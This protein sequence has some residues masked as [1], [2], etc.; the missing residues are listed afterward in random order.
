MIGFIGFGRMGSALVKG[1]IAS[2]FLKPSQLIV[3]DSSVE[4]R[5]SAKVLRLQVATDASEVVRKSDIVFLCVKPQG[6]EVVLSEL[7]GL[8][9]KT[10]FVS[11][12]AGIPIGKLERWLGK[13][14]SVFRVM[15]NTPALLQA[16]MSALS[17]GKYGTLAQ[18]RRVKQILSSVG[19]VVV[20]PEKM[21]DAVTAVSGSGPAY[22]FYLAEALIQGAQQQGLGVALARTL[23][24]QT[25]YGAGLM[26]AQRS[27]SAEELR[28]QVTSPGGT[29]A[30][31]VA[32]FDQKNLKKI[33]EKAVR[34]AAQ[35]SVE[36]AK[37]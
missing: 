35:R 18:E 36:L 26:L 7:K 25:I 12:A 33:V 23:V 19:T 15:P 11:I 4:A 24:H 34:M 1:A 8:K 27:E 17:R 14:V 10:S 22:V 31:A 37:N 28:R 20:L 9:K 16:G 21:M 2:K 5:R 32:V 6:M 3:F 13:N 30:A 29:T